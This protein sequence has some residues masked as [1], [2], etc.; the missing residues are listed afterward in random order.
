MSLWDTINH[1]KKCSYR[2]PESRRKSLFRATPTKAGR[3]PGIQ[4]FK[5]ILDS[6]FR[7]NDEVDHPGKSLKKTLS[8]QRTRRMIKMPGS[9]PAPS[10]R[11]RRIELL[12]K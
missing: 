11:Q 6:G 3:Y 12:E 10:I 7:R 5:R 8:K 9:R 4:G 1:E 2:T